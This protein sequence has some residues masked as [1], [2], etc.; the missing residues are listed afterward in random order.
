MSRCFDHE[1]LRAYR[2]SLEFISWLQNILER[3]PK[4]IA[5]YG[6]LDRASTSVSLNIA[7]GNGK[8]SKKIQSHYLIIALEQALEAASGLVV[9]SPN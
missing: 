5:V 6:H 2:A 7:E 3:V 9:F 1:N 8:F 4:K